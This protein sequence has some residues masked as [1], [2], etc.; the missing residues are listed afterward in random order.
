MID[1]RRREPGATPFEKIA[2][3]FCVLVVMMS[4]LIAA[5][6]ALLETRLQ[7]IEVE[8]SKKGLSWAP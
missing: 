6:F 5:R 7:R 3:V 4:F 2:I 8:I 1:W